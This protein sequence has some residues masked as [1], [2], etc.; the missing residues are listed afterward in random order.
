MFHIF[1]LEPV[2]SEIPV[3]IKPPKLLPENKY[4][5]KKI[6]NYDHKSQQYFVK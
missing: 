2:N 6:I 5:V 1:L 4:E 3:F